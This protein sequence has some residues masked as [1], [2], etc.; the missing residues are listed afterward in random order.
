MSNK[1]FEIFAAIHCRQFCM[2]CNQDVCPLLRRISKAS[3]GK[4]KS[5]KDYS[6]VEKKGG[7][8]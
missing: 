7:C 1:K 2:V 5:C 4:V 3:I 8:A 6:V